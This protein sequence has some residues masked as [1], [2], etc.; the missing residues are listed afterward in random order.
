M[1]AFKPIAIL[2][3]GTTRNALANMAGNIRVVLVAALYGLEIELSLPCFFYS[4][5]KP[6]NRFQT[7]TIKDNVVRITITGNPLTNH[8]YTDLLSVFPCL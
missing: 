6:V 8:G 4:P 1:L 5:L 2:L 3:A 7:W